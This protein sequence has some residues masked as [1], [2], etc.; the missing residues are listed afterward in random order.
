MKDVYKRQRYSY[1]K[2]PAEATREALGVLNILDNRPLEMG[3]WLD[4][5]WSEQRALGKTAI[6]AIAQAFIKS[7]TAAGYKCGIYC[8][9]DWHKNVLD[10]AELNVPCLLYTSHG[11]AGSIQTVVWDVG[12]KIPVSKS[13]KEISGSI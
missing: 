11:S 8:N 9:M 12:E 1:A 10:T 6:T 4:L 3:V 2:N 5:E 7:I 13:G